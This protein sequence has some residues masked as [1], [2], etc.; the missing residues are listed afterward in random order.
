MLWRCWKMLSNERRVLRLCNGGCL[1]VEASRFKLRQ[2]KTMLTDRYDGLVD[3]RW[4]KVWRQT[5]VACEDARTV[6]T[7]GDGLTDTDRVWR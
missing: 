3:G 2:D 1:V 7:S 5:G 4:R 6:E